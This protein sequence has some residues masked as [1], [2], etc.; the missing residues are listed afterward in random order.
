MF[1][2]HFMR[3]VSHNLGG[4][5]L[6]NFVESF[7]IHMGLLAIFL[8]ENSEYGIFHKSQNWC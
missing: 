6:D 2:E 8:G 5:C 7:L 1:A 4:L 3:K